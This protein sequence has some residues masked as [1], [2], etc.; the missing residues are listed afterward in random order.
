MKQFITLLSVVAIMSACRTTTEKQI[1]DES[2]RYTVTHSPGYAEFAAWKAQKAF[3][4]EKA[5]ARAVKP[6]VIYV[7][8]PLKTRTIVRY[9]KSIA[10]VPASSPTVSQPAPAGSTTPVPE[11]TQPETQPVAKKG[12]SKAAKGAVIGAGTGAAAGAILVKKN[13]AL[14]AIIGGVVGG[15]AGYG[16][17]RGMDKKD[18]RTN[19]ALR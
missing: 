14:G 13:R 15:G 5:Q 16:I 10:T 19:L 18:G 1:G 3:E 12:W 9:P 6:T 17:G 8:K 11:T 2:K 7:N 4:A